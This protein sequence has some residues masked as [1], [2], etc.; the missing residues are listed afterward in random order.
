MLNI[1]CVAGEVRVLLEQIKERDE[2]AEC[3]R[4][5]LET[6]E[7][8]K[9][10]LLREIEHNNERIIKLEKNKHR[11]VKT[12]DTL[13][14]EHYVH[15]LEEKLEACRDKEMQMSSEIE[16]LKNKNCSSG[17]YPVLKSTSFGGAFKNVPDDPQEQAIFFFRKL[18]R[19]ESYRKAL[20]W[21]KRYL[22][23]LIFSYQESELLSLG[24]LARMSGGRKMLIADVPRAEGR[25]V[26]FR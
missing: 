21:Q 19:T 23:L 14:N 26:N 12:G 15:D 25:N 18:L 24:R 7:A 17:N 11:A 13:N 9:S 1:L 8:E 2:Q 4:R 20:V 22:S 5:R 3:L 16:F 10:Q 6:I